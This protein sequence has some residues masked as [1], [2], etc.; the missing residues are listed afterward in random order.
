MASDGSDGPDGVTLRRGDAADVEWAMALA[1]E[2]AAFGLP[3]WRDLDV[4]V[5]E[6]RRAIR[7]GLEGESDDRLVF[8]AVGSNGE[9]LG[10]AHVL[11]APDAN[12]GGRNVVVNDLVVEPEQQ[13]RGVGRLLLD[14]C[15]AWGREREAIGLVLAVFQDN[16]GARRL[17]ERYGFGDDVVRMVL[18]LESV[19]ERDDPPAASGR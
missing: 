10:L 9:R 7:D 11:L 5:D 4:F 2:L 8:V 6:C 1:P 17:Y 13:G 12:T 3:V 14:R 16:T 19:A 15:A 18:P